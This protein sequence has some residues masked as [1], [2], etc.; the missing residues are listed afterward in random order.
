LNDQ[1]QF[2]VVKDKELQQEVENKE[3]QVKLQSALAE[4]FKQELEEEKRKSVDV[5]NEFKYYKE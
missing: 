4:K 2:K 3:R 1:N 5:S